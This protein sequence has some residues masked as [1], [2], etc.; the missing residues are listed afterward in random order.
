MT[1]TTYQIATGF[2]Q[3]LGSLADI[4]PQ[5]M[6]PGLQYARRQYAASGKVIDELPMIPL[7][8]DLP[9]TVDQVN[10]L[11]TQF[12]FASANTSQIS[13]YIP[14]EDGTSI[15]RNGVAVK[16]LPGE[17]GRRQGYFVRGLTIL[18]KQLRAQS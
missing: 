9:L 11:Y 6:S 7:L 15:L 10:A 2:D 8:F 13:I 14:L 17:D 5:P 1:I 16:P 3:T 12:G 18:V 4:D